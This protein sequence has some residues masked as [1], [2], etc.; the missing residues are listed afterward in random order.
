MLLCETA[1]TYLKYFSCIEQ[2]G[3]GFLITN[4]TR[5]RKPLESCQSFVPEN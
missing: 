5:T 2:K 1:Y 4:L 3:R